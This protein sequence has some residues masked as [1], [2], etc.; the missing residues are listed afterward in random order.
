[1]LSG[2]WNVF[3]LKKQ[4]LG[5]M[6]SWIWCC[7]FWGTIFTAIEILTP[8]VYS[9]AYLM[10]HG[11]M[12]NVWVVPPAQREPLFLYWFILYIPLSL[13]TIFILNIGFSYL[14][15]LIFSMKTSCNHHTISKV[16]ENLFFLNVICILNSIEQTSVWVILN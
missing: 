2:C 1:M 7:L 12:C 9:Y 10:F 6:T 11:L 13:H 5:F 3:L 15:H 14:Y 8:H 16:C 4:D